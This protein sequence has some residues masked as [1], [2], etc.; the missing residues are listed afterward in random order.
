MRILTFGPRDGG[1]LRPRDWRLG[2]LTPDGTG[3]VDVARA[4]AW[5]RPT[6][7]F[8]PPADP[9]DWY[10]LDAPAHQ[11]LLRLNE[12]MTVDDPLLGELR[13]RAFVTAVGDVRLGSPVPRPGKIVCVGLNYRDH[14]A[15]AKMPVPESPVIFA[16][17]ST[18]VIGPDAPIVIPAASTG[19]VDYEAELAIVMGRV[20]RRVSA[21][22]AAECVLGY[23]NAN[24]VSERAFQKLDGQWVR[25]KSVDT[26]APFGPWIVT[27]DQ[28]ANPN[29][30]GVQLR[31]NGETLQQSRTTEFVFG[32]EAII[33]FLSQ[34]LTFEPGDVIL[35]GT[36]PGVGY[37]R[38]PPVYL[39]PGDLV[40]VE[41][42]G[43]GVLRNPVSAA[44]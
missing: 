27:A 25:A 11:A 36:P 5:W 13:K 26:F 24:D 38:T 4:L 43:L 7:G 28:V 44:E 1:E 33:E 22:S 20:A 9:L 10:D 14:A 17:F 19:R 39:K 23:M 37:A 40:E 15:E 18:A 2:L 42:E 41:I 6:A 3:V 29:D 16:K 32:V 35:T 21:A 12:A 31:L 34:T 8:V 30:L